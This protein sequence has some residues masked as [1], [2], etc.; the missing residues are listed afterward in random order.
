MARMPCAC[1]AVATKRDRTGEAAEFPEQHILRP[2]ACRVAD[3]GRRVQCGEPLQQ[4]RRWRG[5]VRLGEQQPVGAGSLR[6]G[7]GEPVQCR[8]A[9]DT[10]DGG[11]HGAYLQ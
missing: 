7:L 3:A 5:K 9:S 10:V 1:T 2:D 6:R 8:G 4:H 11:H